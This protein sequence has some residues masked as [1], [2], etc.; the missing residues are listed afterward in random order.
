V[1]SDLAP[2]ECQESEGTSLGDLGVVLKMKA[3]PQPPQWSL[4]KETVLS[5][6]N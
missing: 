2:R 1:E 6:P 3:S 5:C 4:M